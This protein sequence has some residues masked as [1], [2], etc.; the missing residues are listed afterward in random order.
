MTLIRKKS[1]KNLFNKK[2][3]FSAHACITSNTPCENASIKAYDSSRL[4]HCQ[5]LCEREKH[6]GQE[7]Q[8]PVPNCLNQQ[9][10]GKTKPGGRPISNPPVLLLGVLVGNRRCTEGVRFDLGTKV[11]GFC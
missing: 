5:S 1:R 11:I 7:M 8:Q 9:D 10:K 2:K 4:V 3:I 6:G